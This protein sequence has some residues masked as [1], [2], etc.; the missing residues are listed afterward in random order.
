M[1]IEK[2][3]SILTNFAQGNNTLE[4]M[5]KNSE[6]IYK[7]ESYNSYWVFQFRHEVIARIYPNYFEISDDLSLND[8]QVLQAFIAHKHIIYS[9]ILDDE[10]YDSVDSIEDLL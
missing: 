5:H 1:I 6:V 8:T 2:A 4:F 7:R 3:F 9:L 10:A